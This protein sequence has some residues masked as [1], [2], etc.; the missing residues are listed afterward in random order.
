MRFMRFIRLAPVVVLVAGCANNAAPTTDTKAA[1]N[2]TAQAESPV[3]RGKYLVT[4]GGCNDCHTPKKPG[5]NGP[6]PD[7]SRQLSG[8]PATDKLPPVPAGAFPL[9]A[10]D[11]YLTIVNNHLGAWV[12]PWGVSF[13]MNLTPD[14]ATGLGSWTEEMFVNALRTGKHQGTGRPILPPMPWYWYRNMT[15][16][17]LKAVFAY[18]QS[19]P[20]IAN[21]IPDPV[22]PDKIPQ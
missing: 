7:M 20:P 14:K 9:G 21:A 16:Q 4:V 12:G 3:E 17:D 15:D 19:L 2:Q 11:R 8:N 10:P 1:G 18:L 5:P 22:P 13:A 6:E